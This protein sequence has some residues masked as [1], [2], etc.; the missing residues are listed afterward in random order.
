MQ[1]LT[2]E[3][4]LDTENFWKDYFD[5]K[6]IKVNPN[7]TECWKVTNKE[8]GHFSYCSSM[9]QAFKVAHTACERMEGYNL[10]I[11]HRYVLDKACMVLGVS[12]LYSQQY[13]KYYRYYDKKWHEPKNHTER[14]IYKY[15]EC[16]PTKIKEKEKHEREI[17]KSFK[18][19]CN[20]CNKE[21]KDIDKIFKC[22][23]CGEYICE[24]CLKSLY[25]YHIKEIC[26]DGVICGFCSGLI[27]ED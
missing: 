5:V 9:L 21:V 25:G 19:T 24:R 14:P 22:E 11:D 6:F 23:V 1:R 2:N 26:S 13:M 7:G 3:E 18:A 20:E 15:G 27:R 10:S 12:D 4:Y 17:I 8:T 16:N